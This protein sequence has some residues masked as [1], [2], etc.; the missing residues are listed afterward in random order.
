MAPRVPRPKATE[1]TDPLKPKTEKAKV[2]KAK[3]DKPKVEKIKM[4]KVSKIKTE[5]ADK[6]KQDKKP[7]EKKDKGDKDGKEKVKAVTGDEAVKVMMEYLKATNRPYSATEI[8]AN[9]HGKVGLPLRKL[10]F[11]RKE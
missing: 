11:C 9:L 7:A 1:E 10:W 2:E 4:E 5:K 3:P 8:S 6:P